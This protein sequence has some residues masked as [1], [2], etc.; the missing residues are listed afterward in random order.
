MLYQSFREEVF[1]HANQ[2]VADGLAYGSQGN[3]SL[4]DYRSG[5]VAITPSAL[6]YRS[7]QPKDICILDLEGTLIDSPWRPTSEI[8]LHLIFYKNRPEIYAVIHTHAPYA[9]TFGV[10]NEPIPMILTEAATCIGGDVPIAPYLRPGTWELAKAALTTMG[11][12]IAVV[13]ANHGLVTVGETL[14][15]AYESAM[16][17]ETS[18]RLS[19]LAHSLGKNPIPLPKPEVEELRK[20]YL[21][22]YHPEQQKK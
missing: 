16:A 12:G 14:A 5:I 17:V 21:K 10:V 6:P 7:M 11:D 13:L 1:S 22:T 18:A 2:M 19:I 8:A 3:I 4:F 20:N 9:T 15:R